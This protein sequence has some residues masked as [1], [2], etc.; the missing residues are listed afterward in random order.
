MNIIFQQELFSSCFQGY[1]SGNYSLHGHR[2]VRCTECPGDVLYS[3]VE[4]WP[5]WHLVDLE[6]EV[7]PQNKE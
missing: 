7:C 1:L 4:T 5:H 6:E 2:D 3:I